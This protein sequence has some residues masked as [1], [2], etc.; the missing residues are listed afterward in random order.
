[1][2]GLQS[3]QTGQRLLESIELAGAIRR[4]D[5]HPGQHSQRLSAH[6]QARAAVALF[7]ELA[8]ALRTAA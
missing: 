8:A 1:M 4:G 3:V 7:D 5:L 6:L 2:R